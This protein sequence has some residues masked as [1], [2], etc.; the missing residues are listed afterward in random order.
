M[1]GALLLGVWA[2]FSF[3]VGAYRFQAMFLVV[4]AVT[5]LQ[6]LVLPA[7]YSAG[8]PAGIVSAMLLFKDVGLAMLFLV[9]L[10]S[11]AVLRLLSQSAAAQLLA[12]FTAYSLA[13]GFLDFAFAGVDLVSYGSVGRQI[14]F[15]FLAVCVGGALIHRHQ[16]S[17]KRTI[18]RGLAFVTWLVIGALV[19]HALTGPEWWAHNANI[20][21]FNLDIRGHTELAQLYDLG[22]AANAEMRDSVWSPFAF[23]IFGSFGDSL[24]FGQVAAVVFAY[25]LAR[26]QERRRTALT[27]L[28]VGA[29]VLFS[30]SRSAWLAAWAM[31]LVV[32]TGMRQWGRILF[33]AS[34]VFI[35]VS[36][37][38]GIVGFVD[39]TL[40]QFGNW[41]AGYE[42]AEGVVRFYSEG[43][44]QAENLLGRGI[45]NRTIPESGYA[46][47]LEQFGMPALL[48]LVA[49]FL[50]AV[51]EIRSGGPHNH[52]PTVARGLCLASLLTLN[53]AEYPFAFTTYLL[54]WSLIGFALM[55][56][57]PATARHR[58]APS[59]A[60]LRA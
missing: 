51:R 14:L 53:F 34:G 31:A 49:F 43:L 1:A 41:R 42:H 24:A 58:K 39:S 7:L 48:L 47:L 60:A 40:A 32:M 9:A 27:V 44:W 26:N 54:G 19:L 16:D 46:W 45:G 25:Q 56:R 36:L 50:V 13:R 8:A 22:L 11:G 52:V 30:F 3:L 12:M 57:Q 17:G 5:C 18:E 33:A 38:P 15:P 28:L 55:Q 23:R 6:G 35:L 29:A 37:T 21:R 10:L 4:L 20:A 2:I 59:T